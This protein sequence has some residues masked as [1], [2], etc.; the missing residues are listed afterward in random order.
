MKKL[1]TLILALGLFGSLPAQPN[2]VDG[3]V[4][5]LRQGNAGQL[6]AYFDDNVE[7]SLPDKSDNFSKA[8]AQ[9]IIRDFFS[10]NGV[11]GFTVKHQGESPG[12]HFLIGM[13]QTRT[14]TLRT[15]VFLKQK[16]GKELVKEIRFQSL[17]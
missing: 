1:L 10:N 16:D 4:S 11:K 12:G 15:N 13:L 7:L 2:P 8:Q 17:E 5:A 14:G 6:A 3:V 9:Q